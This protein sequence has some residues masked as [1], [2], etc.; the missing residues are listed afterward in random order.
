MKIE[1]KLSLDEFKRLLADSGDFKQL[2][3]DGSM[4]VPVAETVESVEAAIDGEPPVKN[5]E[6]KTEVTLETVRAKLADL[7]QSG[8]QAEVKDLLKRHG[9]DKLS[10][11][12]KGNYPAL[13]T[14]AEAM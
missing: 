8:K 4:E 12:P 3:V 5:Q 9:G 13:L 11:I 14:E 7:M 2:L 10:D 6:P 1:I